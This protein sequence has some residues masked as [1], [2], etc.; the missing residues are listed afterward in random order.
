MDYVQPVEALIPGARGRLL[1]VLAR[2]DAPL[3]L[4]AVARLSGIS[5]GQASRVLPRLVELGVV[6]RIDV[7]PSALFELPSRSFAAQLVRN[8]SAARQALVREMRTTAAKLKPPPACIVLFGSVARGTARADSDID[9]LI[10]RPSDDL[11]EDAWTASLTRWASRIREFSGNPL[12]IVEEYEEDIPRLLRAQ[13]ALWQDISSE[14]I[15]L[16]GNPLRKL[17]QKVPKGAKTTRVTTS[18]VRAYAAKAEW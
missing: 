10:V 1:G 4:R 18:D 7:P 14:G 5:S 12:N 6:T 9:V 3:N 8:L 16:A 15:L 11:D 2:A 13:R 17:G